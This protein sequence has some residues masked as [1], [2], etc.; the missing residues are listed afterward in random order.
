MK[1]SHITAIKAIKDVFKTLINGNS[2]KSNDNSDNGQKAINALKTVFNELSKVTNV[3]VK[4]KIQVVIDSVTGAQNLLQAGKDFLVGIRGDFLSSIS[5]GLDNSLTKLRKAFDNFIAQ[6]NATL[7][8]DNMNKSK[9]AECK[10]KLFDN[11]DA[12][13]S[14]VSKEQNACIQNYSAVDGNLTTKID[15]TFK[16]IISAA[17]APLI[18]AQ[19]C[20]TTNQVTSAKLIDSSTECNRNSFMA[21]ITI[22][23]I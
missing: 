9:V 15:T 19:L 11:I 22:V 17:S 5:V 14:N 3:T 12:I 10:K 8:D 4:V 6:V 2:K 1:I 13:M 16:A 20:M 23:S 18:N 7:T 21:C